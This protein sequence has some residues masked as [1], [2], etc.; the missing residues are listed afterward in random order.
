M[1]APFL[2]LT[3]P[4]IRALSSRKDIIILKLKSRLVYRGGFFNLEIRQFENLEI[5]KFGDLE[6]KMKEEEQLWAW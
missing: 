4:N 3:L 6:M 1:E 2:L 5:W